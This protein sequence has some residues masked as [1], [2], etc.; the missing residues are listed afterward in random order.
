MSLRKFCGRTAQV[1]LPDGQP[2]PL[3]CGKSPRCEHHWFYDFR[4]NGRRYR[5]TTDTADKQRAKDIEASERRRILERRHGIRRLPD[6]TFRAFAETYVTDHAE[7]HKRSVDRDREIIKVLNRVFGSLIL[8]E[9]TAHRIEQFKRERLAGKWRGHKTTSAAKSIQPGTVNRELDTLRSIFS[10]AIEWG[11]LIENPMAP[12]KRLKVDNRR[13]RILT[14]EEQVRLLEACP[15]KLRSIVM[16]ALTTGARVGE[17]LD[18]RWEAVQDSEL[19]FLET[20]NGR[21]R[22]MPISAAIAAVLAAQPRVHPWVFTNARTKKPYTVNGVAH[23][24]DRA[25]TRADITTGDVTLHTLRHTA[26]SRMIADGF[27]DYT[28][29]A[30]SGHSSTRMLA[31]YTHPTDAR[32]IGALDLPSVG[33]IWAEVEHDDGETSS[34]ALEIAKLLKEFG[35]PREARTRDLRVANAALSQLS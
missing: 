9:I 4:V 6:I 3:H 26:L 8:H 24:F 27:D 16:L 22:R 7:L 19:T 11:K 21:I 30:I 1:P 20:K 34:T 15:G 35:G 10:K 32:K 5:A 23:V 2:N 17:L 31:R 33:R 14:D 13:T 25:L 28:V 29:M 12:V 18:L